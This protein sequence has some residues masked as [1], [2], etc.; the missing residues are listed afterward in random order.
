MERP[1]SINSQMKE[2]MG[3]YFSLDLGRLFLAH[4]FLA[5]ILDP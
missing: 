5:Q 2:N 1:S 3:N 4:M